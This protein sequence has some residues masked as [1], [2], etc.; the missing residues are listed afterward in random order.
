MFT[1]TTGRALHV[2]LRSDEFFSALEV[3]AR[4]AVAHRGVAVVAATAT[5]RIARTRAAPAVCLPLRGRGAE[6]TAS[7][8]AGD[9]EEDGRGP[10]S[11]SIT[12]PQSLSAS[13]PPMISISS[14][15]IAAWRARL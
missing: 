7:G 3:E 14:F 12:E 1:S 15:V 4:F 8:D 5:G 10:H 11:S 6:R 13:A 9:R 2:L